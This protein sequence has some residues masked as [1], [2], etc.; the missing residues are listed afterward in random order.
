M[1]DLT[2]SNMASAEQK[3]LAEDV[4]AVHRKL[5]PFKCEE[6]SEFGKIPN[7]TLKI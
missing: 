4:K 6:C 1:L 5:K 3:A 2:L 7:Q